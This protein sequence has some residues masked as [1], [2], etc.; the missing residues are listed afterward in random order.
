MIR[1]ESIHNLNT[2]NMKKIILL[3][4]AALCA[5]TAV[6]AQDKGNWG[7]GPQ[8]GIYTNTGAD[9]A[10]FGIGATGR[11]SFT[12]TWRIQPSLTALCK[13]GCSVDIAADV[14]YLFEVASSWDVYPQAGLSA[15]DIGGW[16]CGINLGA[17]T[18]FNVARN[19]DLSAG[20]K[21][22]IQT[23][24]WHKNPIIINIGATSRFLSERRKRG[25][26][27]RIKKQRPTSV[28]AFSVFARSRTPRLPPDPPSPT[29]SCIRSD[30]CP[31]PD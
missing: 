3:T 30:T 29:G 21:W 6:S 13:S 28:S 24:K 16:S 20:F 17:G 27:P 26:E 12:D 4:I 23:A 25:D 18:D 14:Q 31:W 15:N 9:G 8:I 2:K 10:I 11:Y 22:M 1:R 7:V 5:F 19:W